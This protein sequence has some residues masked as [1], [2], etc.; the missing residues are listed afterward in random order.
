MAVAD[1]AEVT[2]KP[3]RA[4]SP[5][6]IGLICVAASSIEWYDFLVYG[7]AAALVFPKLFFPASLSPLVAQLASFSTFS[8]GFIARPVGAV[9]FGHFGDLLGRKRALVVALVMMGLSSAL[10]GALPSYARIGAAAPL[11]LVA[12]RFC[13]GLALGGQWGGAALLAVENAPQARRGLLGSL[14]QLGVA[15]GMIVANLAVLFMTAAVSPDAFLAWGWRVPFGLSVVLIAIGLYVQDRIEETPEFGGANEAGDRSAS[16]LRSPVI[17]VLT[18]YPLR[19]VLAGGSCMANNANF[20][21][22]TTFAIAYGTGALRL[23]RSEVLWAVLLGC[24]ASMIPTV[25]AGALSDRFGRRA[26]YIAGG[27]LGA[28][29]AFL[30]WRLIDTGAFALMFAGLTLGYLANITM[31]APQPALFAELFPVEFRYS[32]ASISYQLGAIMGGGVAPMIATALMQRFHTSIYI[33]AYAALMFVVSMISV[34]LLG[35]TSKRSP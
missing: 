34:T 16:R 29:G 12:L 24:L 13:Q 19:V 28:F 26:V 32:G 1:V 6:K 14:P 18:R 7:T 22:L 25:Y 35:Q 11:L 15:T 10:I 33:A 9:L 2:A 20:Y 17:Q 27:L 5:A 30:T 4:N 31:Y 3:A 8:V 23:P 21:L